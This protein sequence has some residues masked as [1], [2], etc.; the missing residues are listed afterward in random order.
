MFFCAA[1]TLEKSAGKGQ[2][3][4][5]KETGVSQLWRFAADQIDCTGRIYRPC[6]SQVRQLESLIVSEVTAEAFPRIFG[7]K[8]PLS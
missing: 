3:V 5:C 8:N 1:E 7:S 6:G 4:P 2:S